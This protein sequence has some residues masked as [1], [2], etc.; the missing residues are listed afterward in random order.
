LK[1]LGLDFKKWIEAEFDYN[2]WRYDYSNSE[3]ISARYD[4]EI[5][6]P[7]HGSILQAIFW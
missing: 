5:I 4:I 2:N 7:I 3:Y 6:F 1:Y